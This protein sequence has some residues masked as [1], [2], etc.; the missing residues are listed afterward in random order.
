MRTRTGT[1]RLAVWAAICSCAL[2]S[3]LAI[4]LAPAVVGGGVRDITPSGNAS[5]SGV[6][7]DAQ[8]DFATTTIDVLSSSPDH[9]IF[10]H[11][12]QRTKLIPTLNLIT[13]STV[14]AP[15]DDAWRKWSDTDAGHAVA[16]LIAKLSGGG[17]P[18]ESILADNILFHLRQHLFY[19][20]LNYTLEEPQ[21]LK[22]K[23]NDEQRS[24]TTETT[25][26]YP[27][28]E[29]NPPSPL[30][31]PKSPWLPQ[32]GTGS[33]GGQGQR[34][35]VAFNASGPIVVGCGPDGADGAV[36]WTDWYDEPRDMAQGAQGGKKGETRKGMRMRSAGNG[37]VIG[38]DSVLPMPVDIGESP[39]GSP[40]VRVANRLAAQK[41]S[42]R[43]THP[44]PISP[45]SCHPTYPPCSTHPPRCPTSPP[46]RT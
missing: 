36:V 3:Q 22:P 2:A 42:S 40:S 5:P 28:R 15:T 31:P 24:L 35:W 37:V 13:E 8:G 32:D 25:L 46:T 26:L 43:P 17:P 7:G 20:V 11:L 39:I 1:A 23:D 38:V 12:L 19:H 27:A 21:T 4:G 30:P 14:F 44:S 16:P 18:P 45:H 10:I 29:I 6:A 33:L 34:L 9:S 41:P